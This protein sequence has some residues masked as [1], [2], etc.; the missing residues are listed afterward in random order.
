[1]NIVRRNETSLSSRQMSGGL[2]LS[3]PAGF[4]NRLAQR[5]APLSKLARRTPH[6]RQITDEFEQA[7]ISELGMTR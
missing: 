6:F 3:T 4:A 1:V 2:C 5:G 7:S